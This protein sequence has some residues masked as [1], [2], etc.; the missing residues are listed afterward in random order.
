MIRIVRTSYGNAFDLFIT[1][2]AMQADK[3]KDIVCAAVSALIQTLA[4]SMDDISA[5]YDV[6][7]SDEMVSHIGATGKCAKVACD[8]IMKGLK[9][10]A[11]EYPQNVSVEDA[12]DEDC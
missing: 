7:I 2:H 8:V 1:G 11:D 9:A 6:D 3:G 12:V 5:Y 10:I 4:M